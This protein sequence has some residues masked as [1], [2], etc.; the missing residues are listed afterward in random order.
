MSH[1]EWERLVNTN[2][3]KPWPRHLRRYLAGV[4]GPNDA[5]R[6]LLVAGKPRLSICWR[7]VGHL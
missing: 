2:L 1:S 3:R 4:E 5:Q 6:E 7:A